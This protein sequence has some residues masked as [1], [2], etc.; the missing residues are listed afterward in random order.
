MDIAKRIQLVVDRSANSKN[1]ANQAGAF[2]TI[3]SEYAY[4]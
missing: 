1:A 3:C 4:A 2:F